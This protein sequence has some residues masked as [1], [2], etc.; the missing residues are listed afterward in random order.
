V[1]SLSSPILG[2][3]IVKGRTRPRN[4]QQAQYY[5]FTK[6]EKKQAEY[7]GDEDDFSFAG[8]GLAGPILANVDWM[9]KFARTLPQAVQFSIRRDPHR[10]KARIFCSGQ[11]Q[12]A[13]S[14]GLKT[15]SS[16]KLAQTVAQFLIDSE[17]CG[18]PRL[19]GLVRAGFVL[20]ETVG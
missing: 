19:G 16:S 2:I 14:D 5:G 10:V 7:A 20:K 13:R 4:P 6:E 12:G 1:C 3:A 8:L 18:L 11:R 17:G 9:F 15:G